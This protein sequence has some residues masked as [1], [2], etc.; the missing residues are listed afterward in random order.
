MIWINGKKLKDPD[1]LQYLFHPADTP[2]ARGKLSVTISYLS[3][4][5]AECTLMLLPAKGQVECA[6]RDPVL[7][8]ERKFPAVMVVGRCEKARDGY[9]SGEITLTEVKA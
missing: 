5:D 4:T 6:L 8:V 1:R 9:L 2:D 3:L 7:S